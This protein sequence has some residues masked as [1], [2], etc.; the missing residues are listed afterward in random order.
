LGRCSKQTVG[1]CREALG[2]HFRPMR[3]GCEM[4]EASRP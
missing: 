3:S 2:L 4:T 1:R